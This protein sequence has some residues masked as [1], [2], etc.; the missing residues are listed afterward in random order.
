M[1]KQT[2]SKPHET[3]IDRSNP[4]PLPRD[5][6]H[7]HSNDQ[8]KDT[9]A[10][11]GA[12]DSPGK[13]DTT[14]SAAALDELVSGGQS[15]PTA[16]Q[17]GGQTAE[18]DLELGGAFL[19]PTFRVKKLD[20][21]ARIPQYQSA[22]AAC[23]DLHAISPGHVAPGGM[24]TFNTGLAFEVPEGFVMKVYSRSGHGVNHMVRLANGTGIID[25]DY[26]GEVVVT[27]VN[28]HRS[29]SFEV[30]AGDR[31]AQAML[32]QAPQWIIEEADE[33]SA[34]ARGSNGHGSTGA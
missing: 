30:A 11:T 26:R 16:V 23:F 4:D 12:P 3:V 18:E 24:M 21:A 22:G 25:S 28:D 9:S 32:E 31:V 5:G 1:S 33:L 27:L 15:A 14:D 10:A 29:A 20:S 6:A 17:V 7:A 19:H 34:T 8:P 13:T 2:K